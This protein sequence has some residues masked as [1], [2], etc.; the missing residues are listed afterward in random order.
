MIEL[1]ELNS[2][3]RMLEI[4]TSCSYQIT[5]SAHFF[6]VE[7]IL[8]LQA[9]ACDRLTAPRSNNISFRL[10][11]GRQGW[12]RDAPFDTIITEVPGTL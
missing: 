12:A 1:F 4:G 9:E 10:G 3:G 7:F 5:V 11:D 6:T 2:G 8:E